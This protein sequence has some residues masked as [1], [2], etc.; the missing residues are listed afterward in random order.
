MF[1]VHTV[2]NDSMHILHAFMMVR[3]HGGDTSGKFQLAPQLVTTGDESVSLELY[4][5][6]AYVKP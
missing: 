6:P 1:L 2:K 4:E 3:A 5:K